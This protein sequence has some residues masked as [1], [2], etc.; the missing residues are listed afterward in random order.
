MCVCCGRCLGNYVGNN[1]TALSE[2]N[3]K[4]TLE[5]EI[6]H[7]DL[8]EH[9]ALLQVGDKQYYFQFEEEPTI[10]EALEFF[11]KDSRFYKEE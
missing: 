3:M 7:I 1:T 8:W 2:S 5:Y 6:V 10:H 11:K 9:D 4:Q